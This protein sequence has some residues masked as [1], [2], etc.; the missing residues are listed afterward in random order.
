MADGMLPTNTTLTI[1][2][3]NNNQ[4]ATVTP[5]QAARFNQMMASAGGQNALV[6]F[7]QAV[8]AG[9][10]ILEA[11]QLRDLVEDAR[12]ARRDVK[13]AREKLNDYLG[14][15]ST[16]DPRQLQTLLGN[17]MDAQADLDAS[18]NDAYGSV[19]DSLWINAFGASASVLGSMGGMGGMYDEGE[20]DGMKLLAAGGVGALLAA[21][22]SGS[23]RRRSRRG[24]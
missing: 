18:Q 23:G 7:G 9:G 24:R 14:S 5:Q 2:D 22:F 19:I 10:N 1:Y 20:G 21:A 12:D 3:A 15:A 6:T 4:V 16:V 11:L 8:Q 17:V 13:K